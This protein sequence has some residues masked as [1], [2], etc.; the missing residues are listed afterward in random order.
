MTCDSFPAQYDEIRQVVSDIN[1]IMDTVSKEVENELTSRL[2]VVDKITEQLEEGLAIRK[3]EL[4]F[5]N[6]QTVNT[7]VIDWVYFR[8]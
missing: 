4:Q 6:S 5:E 7:H 8:P 1:L 2:A 3:A